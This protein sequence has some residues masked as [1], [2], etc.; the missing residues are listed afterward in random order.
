MSSESHA[1][2][3]SSALANVDLTLPAL[4]ILSDEVGGNLAHTA[5]PAAQRATVWGPA[6]GGALNR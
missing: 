6:E 3:T 1:S 4:V 2:Q 5:K